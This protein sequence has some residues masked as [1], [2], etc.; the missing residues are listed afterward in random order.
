MIAKS[1]SASN[2]L[3]QLQDELARHLLN[4]GYS[5]RGNVLYRRS[6]SGWS[7]VAYIEHHKNTARD[8]DITLLVGT[9]SSVLLRFFDPERGD[10]RPSLDQLHWSQRIGHLMGLG[11]DKW[12]NLQERLDTAELW[13]EIVDAIDHFGLPALL[14][15]ESDEQLI[16]SWARGEPCGLNLPWMLLHCVILSCLAKDAIA[17]TELSELGSWIRANPQATRFRQQARA[18][19]ERLGIDT[20]SHL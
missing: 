14:L 5:G 13:N 15:H 17:E 9:A 18:S 4:Q 7:V 11:R 8:F 3:R 10:F 12:W 20:K 2:R 16:A 1:S 19:L 6:R